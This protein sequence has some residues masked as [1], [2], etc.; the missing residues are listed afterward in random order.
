[1]KHRKFVVA[2]TLILLGIAGAVAGLALYTNYSV[3]AS[4][5]TLPDALN[6]LPADCQFVF[7]MN[8]QKFVASPVYAKMQQRQDRPIGNDLA[9]FIEKTGVDPTRDTSY[10]VTAGRS[11]EKG[12]GQG[13]VIVV[14]TF[15]KDAIIAYIRSKATPVETAYGDATIM[16]FPE[17]TGDALNNGIVFLNEREIAL[18]NLEYLKAVLDVRMKGNQSILS[19]PTM[20]SLVNSINPDEMFWFAGDAAG[21]LSNATVTT[22]LGAN[23]SSIQ[24]IVGTLNITEAVMGK[25]TVTAVDADAA[26]KLADVA[27]GFVALGQLAGDQNPDIKTLLSGLSV[28]Q[29]ANQISVALNFPTD[30]LDK[31]HNTARLPQTQ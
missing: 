14:G 6:N 8:V 9:V 26:T 13:V 20:A 27:K 25:I 24:N 22:P 2:S 16:M 3:K 5:P 7:G 23:I 21:V 18:G 4:A 11:H 19:N 28:L 10:L 17:K 30:L 15:N 1:M 31:L 29:N 12:K